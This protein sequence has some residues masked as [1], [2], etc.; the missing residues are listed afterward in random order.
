MHLHVERQKT[1]SF[2]RGKAEPSPRNPTG[3][4]PCLLACVTA[5]PTPSVLN[6]QH[7][8]SF[9][10]SHL[11]A[12]RVQASSRQGR[13]HSSPS[14]APTHAYHSASAAIVQAPPNTTRA[15][16]AQAEAPP[17]KHEGTASVIPKRPTVHACPGMPHECNTRLP[18]PHPETPPHP[19]PIPSTQTCPLHQPWHRAH[20]TRTSWIC[21]L[22]SPAN[23]TVTS[24]VHSGP[25][26]PDARGAVRVMAHVMLSAAPGSDSTTRS[27]AWAGGLRCHRLS[28]SCGTA[29]NVAQHRH[30]CAVVEMH[31]FFVLPAL[32][33]H[34]HLWA[35]QIAKKPTTDPILAVAQTG[36]LK[37]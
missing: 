12:L 3:I 11:W 13:T 29:H 28:E 20:H 27:A 4:P 16:S 8:S 33:P 18:A 25:P 23:V 34:R 32:R 6:L 31:V 2:W 36:L 37:V 17:C 9:S 22:L 14:A 5:L 15:P 24:A 1:A 26:L 21:T 7:Q 10:H 30:V 19:S 35:V